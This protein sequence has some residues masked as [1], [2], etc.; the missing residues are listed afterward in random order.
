MRVTAKDPEATFHLTCRNV[1][2]MV[3]WIG[4]LNEFVT[5]FNYF[6]SFF[7]KS[8]LSADDTALYE[9][10]K[11]FILAE[12]KL[13][14]SN[15]PVQH[16][17][18]PGC[19]VLFADNKKGST[20]RE[21]KDHVTTWCHF[22]VLPPE[23]TLTSGWTCRERCWHISTMCGTAYVLLFKA[24][25][26]ICC[27]CGATYSVSQTGKHI[28]KEECIY[29]YGKGVTNKGQYTILHAFKMA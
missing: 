10:L 7:F 21:W 20:D 25:K 5:L 1:K 18:K 9:G 23:G 16:P 6:D 17:E 15:Y 19:A 8:L 22:Y 12:E 28:R 14:E 4:P 27:R 24:L 11:D 3:R 13:I 29:H 2:E 26:R